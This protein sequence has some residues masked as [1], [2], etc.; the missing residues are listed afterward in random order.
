MG[1]H[2]FA[3]HNENLGKDVFIFSGPSVFGNNERDFDFFVAGFD[4]DRFC[5]HFVRKALQGELGSALEGFEMFKFANE[6]DVFSENCSGEINASVE[7][8]FRDFEADERAGCTHFTFLSR[9]QS[10]CTKGPATSGCFAIGVDGDGDL[11]FAF[12]DGDF[13]GSTDSGREPREFDFDGTFV[14]LAAFGFDD[15]RHRSVANQRNGRCNDFEEKGGLLNNGYGQA[16]VASRAK[17][18]GIVDL[19]MMNVF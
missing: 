8:R 2:S 5:G 19:N 10:G 12:G 6:S 17:R 1:N 14:V 9:C 16:F 4:G 11:V 3:L 13:R 15:E 18:S 7:K